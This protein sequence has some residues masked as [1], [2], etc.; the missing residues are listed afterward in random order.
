MHIALVHVHVLPDRVTEFEAAT[1]ANAAGSRCEPGVVRFDVLR[2][3]GDPTRFALVEVY[4]TP[5]AAA[6]H[7][8]TPHYLVWRDAVAPMMAAPRVGVTYANVSP[9]DADW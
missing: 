4:R 5:E 7:K 3:H 6:A 1:E 8:Q 9:A 2:Q